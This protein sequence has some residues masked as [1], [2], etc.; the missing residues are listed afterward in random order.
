MDEHFGETVA[1]LLAEILDGIAKDILRLDI[2]KL[3]FH[4]KHNLPYFI[5]SNS[6]VSAQNSTYE[7]IV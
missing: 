4:A 1:K 7:T 2:Q 5:S 3:I 6:V